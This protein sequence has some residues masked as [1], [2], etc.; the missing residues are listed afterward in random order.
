MGWFDVLKVEDIDFSS[1][2]TAMGTYSEGPDFDDEKQFEAFMRKLMMDKLFRDK[3]PEMK[4]LVKRKIRI[5]HVKIN[6]FLTE[7]LGKAPSEDQLINFITRV[8][9]HE[10]THAGMG[11]EQDGMATHQAEYGAYTGQFPESSYLRLKEFVKHPATKRVLF[12]P[13]LAAGLGFSPEDIM[14]NLIRTPDIIVRV[15]EMI[16]LIDGLTD[17]LGGAKGKNRERLTR[18]E[19]T[20]R[21]QGKAAVRDLPEF[22]NTDEVYHY[23]IERYGKKN[24]DLI[25]AIHTSQ[26]HEIPTK[27]AAMAVT[28]TSAPSMFNNKAIRR[29]KKKKEDWA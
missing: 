19:L 1:K 7:K 23:F 5:N 12:P 18:L 25:D 3:N 16:A 9:M 27:K 22:E 21:Q 13:E 29:K 24:K 15:E 14:N 11:E 8:I 10:A 20:A 6:E 26:G 4:D 17:E 2:G 28:T